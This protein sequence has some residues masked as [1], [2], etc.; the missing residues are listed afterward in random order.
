M[1]GVAKQGG[2]STNFTLDYF[3]Q[4][5]DGLRVIIDFVLLIFVSLASFCILRQ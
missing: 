4:V 2:Y 3:T 1:P 5:K